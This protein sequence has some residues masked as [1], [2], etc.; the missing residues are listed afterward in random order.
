MR[1]GALV[2]QP[3][4]HCM[5]GAVISPS[6]P[7]R[8][9]SL[10]G[11]DTIVGGSWCRRWCSCARVMDSTIAACARVRAPAHDGQLAIRLRVVRL[12]SEFIPGRPW[13]LCVPP[14]MGLVASFSSLCWRRLNPGR[15][16][17]WPLWAIGCFAI[18]SAPQW[19][20]RAGGLN[21]SP[22]CFELVIFI[23]SL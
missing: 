12:V 23:M 16:S 4:S 19:R 9:R 20:V 17:R 8:R 15:R 7:K 2:A 1:S 22:R 14:L 3:S 21:A 5:L 18:V 6:A 11:P 10:I 13:V